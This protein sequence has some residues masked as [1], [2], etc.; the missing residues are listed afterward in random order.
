[1]TRDNQRQEISCIGG[2]DCARGFGISDLRRYCAIGAGLTVRN[3]RYLIQD[4]SLKHSDMQIQRYL[5]F[6][7]SASE[8]H[9]YLPGEPL[10]NLTSRFGRSRRIPTSQP[11]LNVLSP[12]GGVI[13][14]ELFLVLSPPLPFRR[15][16]FR[17]NI[18]KLECCKPPSHFKRRF[19]VLTEESPINLKISSDANRAPQF[20]EKRSCRKEIRPAR[21][22]V[23]PLWRQGCR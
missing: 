16:V 18:C 6:F 2:A 10:V 17:M 22:E 23:M 4:S 13:S 7:S 19:I 8:I 9:I 15:E 20:P 11:V 14:E 21:P 3:L 5:K 12:K 1:M